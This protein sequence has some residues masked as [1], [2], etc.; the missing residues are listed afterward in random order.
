MRDSIAILVAKAEAVAKK[1]SLKL[2]WFV[3]GRYYDLGETKPIPGMK[4]QMGY[5]QIE[6]ETP[7]VEGESLKQIRFMQ[8]YER[9]TYVSKAERENGKVEDYQ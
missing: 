4:W 7:P 1:H 8:D 9:K 3:G 2:R 5:R 6:L